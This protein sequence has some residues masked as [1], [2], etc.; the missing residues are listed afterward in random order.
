MHDEMP[1]HN[2]DRSTACLLA[3][4]IVLPAAAMSGCRANPQ[5]NP[6][7]VPIAVAE[8]TG[9][10]VEPLII[11]DAG[12]SGQYVVEFDGDPV[13]ITLDGS[14]STDADGAIVSY[15]WL[16]ATTQPDAGGRLVPSGEDDNWPA[17]RRRSEVT[18]D[19]GTWSFSLWVIDNDGLVSDQVVVTIRVGGDEGGCDPATCP[20]PALGAPCCTTADTGAEGDPRGRDPDRCGSDLGAL[21]PTLAGIC[22]QLEQPGEASDECPEVMTST[23]MVEPGC[24]T[25]EGL[26][27]GIN[28]SV[29]LGCHYQQTGP[30]A[31]CTP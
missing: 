2:N 14:E 5:V 31:E 23:G 30:G 19:E 6:R 8:V 1:T 10:G 25:D 4:A 24:C 22:L 11:D 17:D 12:V 26:C 20:P 29:P 7:R 28:T 3:L 21:I 18:L 9:S 15:R 16:S 27:A 13:E